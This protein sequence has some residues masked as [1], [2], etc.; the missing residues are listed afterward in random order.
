MWNTTL[1]IDDLPLLVEGPHW[2]AKNNDAESG[3]RGN[4]RSLAHQ[5]KPRLALW[6][7][8]RDR[9]WLFGGDG[10]ITFLGSLAVLFID[11]F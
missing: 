3:D 10:A 7:R 6:W 2:S 4:V 11:T 5:K 1:D 8:R 9:L